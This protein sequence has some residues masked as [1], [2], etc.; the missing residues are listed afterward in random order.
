VPTE[1]QALFGIG[2]VFASFIAGE[3]VGGSGFLAAF[4]AGFAVVLFNNELCECFVEYGEVTAEMAML[5]AFILLGAALS[6]VV[7]GV[8]LG[9]ALLFAFITLAVARPLAIT[10]VLQRA[11]V[12]RSARLFIAF[13]GPRGLNSLLLMLLVI[14]AGVSGADRL[15]GIVG[16]VVM[17]SV[18]VHGVSATPLGA[19]YARQRADTVLPEERE[20]TAAGLFQ[21]PASD[22]PRITP[23]ELAE[24]MAGAHPPLV[25]DVRT[26]SQYRRDS[27]QIPG[28]VRVPPD[29]VT[30]WAREQERG[31]LI[32]AYCT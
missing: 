12:S 8:P 21:G 2:L 1:Y 7:G 23:A 24:L 32:V 16:V 9:A 28:S 26:G 29:E 3:E 19:W 10:A 30:A 31:R 25:L 13:F 14:H 27:T 6:T 11:T 17:V 18:V 5:L 15:L 22:A 20:S 4:V